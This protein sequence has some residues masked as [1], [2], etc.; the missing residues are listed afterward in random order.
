MARLMYTA[1]RLVESLKHLPPILVV[2][3]AAIA[4]CGEQQPGGDSLSESEAGSLQLDSQP[5][6]LGSVAA[7]SRADSCVDPTPDEPAWSNIKWGERQEDGS[8]IGTSRLAPALARD[9]DLVRWAGKYSLFAVATAGTFRA[10][11]IWGSLTLEV[12]ADSSG[13]LPLVGSARSQT[14]WPAYLTFLSEGKRDQPV[15]LYYQRHNRGEITLVLGNAV[16]ASDVGVLFNVFNID[17]LGMVGRWVDGG[18]KTLVDS[19]GREL[20]PAQGYFC[21]FRAGS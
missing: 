18:R 14:D 11:T 21:L 6:L 13:A 1:P 20:G 17:S 12:H 7:M 8:R 19:T 10:D 5:Q 4:G 9:L 15:V 2:G 16:Q 3:I